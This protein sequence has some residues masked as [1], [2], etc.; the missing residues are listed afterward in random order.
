MRVPVAVVCVTLAGCFVQEPESSAEDEVAEKIAALQGQVDLMGAQLA[1]LDVDGD[2]ALDCV[3]PGDLE[4]LVSEADFAVLTTDVDD[5]ERRVEALETYPM[6]RVIR[7]DLS[8]PDDTILTVGPGSSD[9]FPTIDAALASLDDAIIARGTTV[10]IDVVDGHDE[11]DLA[12]I[13][14]DHRDGDNIQ[15]VGTPTDSTQNELR[16]T[17]H[18]LQIANGNVLGGFNGF[19][20]IGPGGPTSVGVHVSGGAIATVGPEL[21][22]RTFNLGYESTTQS[23]LIA[24]STHA[25][26]TS[27]AFVAQQGGQ[28]SANQAT[29][30]GSQ[31]SGFRATEGSGI[32]ASGAQVTSQASF[33]VVAYGASGGGWLDATGSRAIGPTSSAYSAGTNAII[34]ANNS[35]VSGRGSAGYSYLGHD[36][37]VISLSGATQV[38]S[39]GSG[40]V[41]HS[42]SLLRVTNGICGAGQLGGSPS[43]VTESEYSTNSGTIISH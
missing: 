24:D 43:V 19:T 18:G 8:D 20:L 15:I 10:V 40:C 2:G 1:A 33:G 16:F 12:P 7:D 32:T 3:L 13:V 36:A 34:L 37:G 17:G 11:S 42:G 22:V 21:E 26:T 35:E 30:S 31:G 9:E 4:S 41:A 25:Q 29:V 28:I 38:G 23:F 5:H 6:A 27:M 14:I 39:E